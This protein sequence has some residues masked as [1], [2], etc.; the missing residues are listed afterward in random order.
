[1]YEG[2]KNWYLCEVLHLFTRLPFLHYHVSKVACFK[3]TRSVLHTI[4]PPLPPPNQTSLWIKCTYFSKYTNF[5]PHRKN[6]HSN[7]YQ[8]IKILFWRQR[9]MWQLYNI[10][11]IHILILVFTVS[12]LCSQK[13]VSFPQM[14]VKYIISSS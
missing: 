12:A 3:N 11:F 1:M 9:I 6:M 5:C 4:Q 14:L 2:Q 7:K 10:S 8:K 13:Q